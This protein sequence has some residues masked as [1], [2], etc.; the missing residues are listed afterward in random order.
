MNSRCITFLQIPGQK[1]LR[2]ETIFNLKI[3]GK[4]FLIIDETGDKRRK[5]EQI[6][7]RQYLGKLGNRQQDCRSNSL[8]LN[9]WDY[10]SL[11]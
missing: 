2:A 3:K 8:G 6:V 4:N 10:V 9:R 5:K 11:F 1:E 7:N